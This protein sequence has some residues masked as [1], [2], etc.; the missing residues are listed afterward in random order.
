MTRH[1]RTLLDL[2]AEEL[3]A[4]LDRADVLRAERG[5][6][7]ARPLQSKTVLILLEKASTRTRI[8]FEVGIHEL[9]GMP[10]T[11]IAKDSQ[12]GRGEPLSD[13]AHIFSGYVHAVIY[14]TF[15]HA[16]IEELAQH[17][18]IPVI[19]ALSDDFHP[20]QLL[21]DLQTVRAELGSLAGT[22][23]AWIGD[24]NNMAHSWIYAAA[25]T[26][27]DLRLACPEGYLPK[28]EFVERA[29]GLG[30]NI[31]VTTDPVAAVEGAQVVTTDVWAS[32]GQE[33]ENAARAKAFAR[34][35]VDADLMSGAA[36]EAIFLHCLPAHRGEEV[37]GEV[38]DGAQSRV[39][40]EAENRLHAQKALLELLLRVE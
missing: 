29:R 25:L 37:T 34:Y 10:L 30:A 14:R 1:F 7:Q 33:A 31:T 21:A 35:T 27:L 11:L 17:A 3:T 9:G 20:C 36:S 22:S 26:G 12:L 39:W 15:G 6:D 38:I 32:M 2:S 23:V 18:S 16:Q 24:G 40:V 5:R 19:N 4:L 13:S 8:S 28:A